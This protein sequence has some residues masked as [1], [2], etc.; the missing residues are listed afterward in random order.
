MQLS[1]L[2]VNFIIPDSNPNLH[3]SYICSI[4]SDPDGLGIFVDFVGTGF[5]RHDGEAPVQIQI[6]NGIPVVSVWDNINSV[7][8]QVTNLNN[9]YISKLNRKPTIPPQDVLDAFTLRAK[10]LLEGI[11][12]EHTIKEINVKLSFV[13]YLDLDLG[14][15]GCD[16]IDIEC[17][18]P[19]TPE[20]E[21][22]QLALSKFVDNNF[23]DAWDYIAS[24]DSFEAF[25]QK[26][27]KFYV[28]GETL[29]DNYSG[30]NLNTFLENLN[31]FLENLN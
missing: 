17:R 29:A 11:C 31:T 20:I 25:G 19:N 15:V 12:Y 22:C 6:V 10:E 21:L 3:T 7:A 16:Y 4:E 24:T 5:Q 1:S 2:P 23:E 27:H 14:D 9:A 18:S 8:P 30:F 13:L 26:V 28:D